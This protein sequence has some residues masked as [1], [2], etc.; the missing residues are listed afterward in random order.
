MLPITRLHGL[1]FCCE[2]MGLAS[3]NLT[4]LIPKPV[5]LC[6][7]MCNRAIG[8]FKVN[9]ITDFDTDWKPIC[10]LLL[11]NTCNSN[12][13]PVSHHF[14][15]MKRTGQIIAFDRGWLCLTAASFGVNAW[16]LGQWN[17]ASKTKQHS[18]MRHAKDFGILNL[19]G[20]H[21]QCDRR[22]ELRQQ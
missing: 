11:V 14:Q 3:V 20:V 22:T 13:C 21:Y 15:V 18:I 16:T 17:V 10:N 5:I 9:Q 8:P 12:L 1:H 6:Q 2:S 19:L 4:Q 7:I